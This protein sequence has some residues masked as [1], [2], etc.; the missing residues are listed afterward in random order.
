MNIQGIVSNTKSN[1]QVREIRPEQLEA[2]KKAAQNNDLDEIIV[3]N[4]KGTFL[5]YGDDLSITPN[6]VDKEGLVHM[7]NLS[8]RG[9]LAP[10][11]GDQ[12]NFGEL[13]GKLLF[14]DNEEDPRRIGTTIG[15]FVGAIAGIGIGT[16]LMSD[17]SKL[18][19][20]I[21]IFLGG[22]PGALIGGMAGAA[23]GFGINHLISRPE[24]NARGLEQLSKPLR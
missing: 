24:P 12:V 2:V 15:G 9:G 1:L 7:T 21:S 18:G 13:K 16:S 22:M 10:R 14:H 11:A 8:Q 17:G 5:I 23:A 20:F 6:Y 3:S 19:D 4:D